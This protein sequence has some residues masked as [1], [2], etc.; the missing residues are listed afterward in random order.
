LDISSTLAVLEA[1]YS[2]LF[3]LA[4]EKFHEAGSMGAG[5]SALSF[6]ILINLHSIVL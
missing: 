3:G 1:K 6:C 4:I 5:I 2:Q